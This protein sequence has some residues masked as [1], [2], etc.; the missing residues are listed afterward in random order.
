MSDV[1]MQKDG[2]SAG[3]LVLLLLWPLIVVT[4]GLYA[5]KRYIDGQLAD[6]PPVVYIDELKAVQEERGEGTAAD[7]ARRASDRAREA[8]RILADNGYIVLQARS[9]YAAP[10]YLEVAP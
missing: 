7:R 6:R 3:T 1:V 2:M 4:V 10:D 9:V 5:G 8:G